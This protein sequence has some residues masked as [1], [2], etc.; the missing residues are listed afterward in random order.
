MIRVL[1]GQGQY[2][3][4]KRVGTVD[5]P[6]T[7]RK[8]GVLARSHTPYSAMPGQSKCLYRPMASIPLIRR[9]IPR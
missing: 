5:Y 7:N 4:R 6:Y 3:F 2:S 9:Y 1:V 8:R